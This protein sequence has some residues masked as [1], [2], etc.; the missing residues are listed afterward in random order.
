MISKVGSIIVFITYLTLN[1][2]LWTFF[3]YMLKQFS[4]RHMLEI[5]MIANVTSKLWAFIHCVLLKFIHC[6]P[7]YFAISVTFE[8]FMRK[9]TKINT[10]DQHFIYVMQKIPRCLTIWTYYFK[11]TGSDAISVFRISIWVSVLI[12][13]M[14]IIALL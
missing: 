9:F 13:D 4:S 10:I 5:F 1:H 7:N 11:L 3:L 6:F 14:L 2:D 12:F 8:T